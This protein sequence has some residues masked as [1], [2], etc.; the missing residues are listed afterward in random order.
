A[1]AGAQEQSG[2]AG[3][4]NT[5]DRGFSWGM[6]SMGPLIGTMIG[7]AIGGAAADGSSDSAPEARASNF[8]NILKAFGDE[9]KLGNF[10]IQDLS[11]QFQARQELQGNF[12]T[13]VKDLQNQDKLGN[14]EIQGLMSDFN[15]AQTL[16]NSSSS[17]TGDLQKLDGSDVQRLTD[18]FD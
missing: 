16:F 3:G 14:F 2:I 9:G 8:E 17:Q 5:V 18:L 10:E 11:S 15:E 4:E 7:Q 12:E 1:D 6:D 13:A